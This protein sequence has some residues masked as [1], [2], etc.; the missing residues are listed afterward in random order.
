AEQAHKLFGDLTAGKGLSAR[1]LAAYQTMLASGD[2][3]RVL[4]QTAKESGSN[5]DRL[6][7]HRH[8][9]LHAAL[10][11]EIKGSQK[12][13]ARALGSMRIM[14]DASEQSFKEFDEITRLMGGHKNQNKLLDSIL[15]TRNIDD[16]SVVVQRT[17]GQTIKAAIVEVAINGL[18]SGLKTHAINFASNFGQLF[19][20][21]YDKYLAAA[22]GRGRQFA[23]LGQVERITLREANLD[24]VTKVTSTT[25]ALRLGRQAF[26]EGKPITDIRQR[27]EFDTR[28]AITSNREDFV[29]ATINAVG[30]L[31]RI[32]GRGLIAGDEVFKYMNREAETV[33][34]SYRQA[35][36]EADHQKLTGAKREKYIKDR[37]K[38]LT[39]EPTPEIQALAVKRARYYTFQENPRTIFGPVIEKAINVHPFVKLVIAPFM[40][41]PLNILRQA[42]IDRTPLALFMKETREAIMRGGVEGDMAIARMTMGTGAMITGYVMMDK[43]TDP[44]SQIQV[45]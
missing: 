25:N 10:M 31:I 7:V 33:S 42:F 18:L 40:R 2:R 41:T 8:V 21:T 37:S 39:E 6:A 20:G 26:K 43:L 11:A 15:Q 16:L 22:I 32:P 9:E 23:G 38:L 24:F 19:I 1:M 27:I 29:G 17:T 13:I 36:M 30:D 45:V 44:E 5:A 3:L 12:E 14:K 28:R 35:W 34:L 4:A